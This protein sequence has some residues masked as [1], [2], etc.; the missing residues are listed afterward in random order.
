MKNVIRSLF[1][2]LFAASVF[3]SPLAGTT[4]AQAT[5]EEG[6]QAALDAQ[7]ATPAD[8]NGNGAAAS[9]E[10]L[11]DIG[12]IGGVQVDHD[13]IREAINSPIPNLANTTAYV[14]ATLLVLMN[15]ISGSQAS[16]PQ[17]ANDSVTG[18]EQLPSTLSEAIERR[19]ALGGMGFLMA[20]LIQTPPAS[21]QTY[22]ADVMQNSR[23]GAAPVYAQGVGFGALNPVL[24]TWKAFRDVAYYL[25]ALAFIVVGFLI[26]IRHQMGGKTA[27]TVQLALPRLVITLLAIT[28]SYAIA[29]LLVD[30][31]FISLYFILNIFTSQIFVDGANF[32]PNNIFNSSNAGAGT[33]P[34]DIAF[35]VNIFN[36]AL[37]YIFGGNGS[38]AWNA[39]SA[40]GEMAWQALVSAIA[41]N[42]TGDTAGGQFLESLAQFVVGSVFTLIFALA[43]LI[44]VFRTF[45]S[46]LQSYAGFIINVVL[47]PFI[48]L[49]GALPDGKNHIEEWI[50][51]LLGG[52]APFV[53]A[54]FMIFMSL[55]LTGSETRPGIG[56]CNN[57]S[58]NP[59]TAC[60]TDQNESG[61]RL[62]LVITAD[63]NSGAVVGVLGM[64]FMLLLPEAVDI[65][66]KMV[67]AK[68]GPLDE[69]Q[70]K[71][72][73]N[74]KKGWEGDKL[75][76][77]NVPG[78]K[79]AFTG[80]PASQK[81]FDAGKNPLGRGALGLAQEVLP[82]VGQQVIKGIR[83]QQVSSSPPPV[84]PAEPVGTIRKF[85]YDDSSFTPVG[86]SSATPPPIKLP[87]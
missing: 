85:S 86:G 70:K 39:A 47:S 26:L 36:F 76:P 4:Y 15:D 33:T 9:N 56:Y 5:L 37:N 40:L 78:A 42:S 11:E 58:T 66:K 6:A 12:P 81:Q 41:P 72:V 63:L 1:V 80:T 75:G 49:Q 59:N 87:K 77:V 82:A 13:S 31:M 55:A 54:V 61:L 19:G 32:F 20:N 48:L 57:N 8:E 68:G 74:F 65:A 10:N 84:T 22:V 7:D 52:L 38:G 50:R 23:F 62:P 71:A 21:A 2:L 25:L 64:G 69:F 73:D 53:V 30:I 29:G 18:S 35:N 60:T 45:F 27:V 79:S 17:L 67:G 44:A 46:L 16:Q 3:L 34:A 28:F 51:N 24:G 14:Y 43:L 83:T